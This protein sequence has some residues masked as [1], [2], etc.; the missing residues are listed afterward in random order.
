MQHQRMIHGDCRLVAVVGFHACVAHQMHSKR[1]LDLLGGGPCVSYESGFE[2]DLLGT[3][4]CGG[5][6]IELVLLLGS[7]RLCLLLCFV[8]DAPV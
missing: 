3:F 7:C 8:V 5:L 6:A 1:M 4:S 2:S